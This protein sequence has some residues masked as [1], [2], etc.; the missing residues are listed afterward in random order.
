ML[1]TSQKERKPSA[2]VKCI[3]HLSNAVPIRILIIINLIINH[4]NQPLSTS[5]SAISA[6]E[7]ENELLLEEGFFSPN[8]TFVSSCLLEPALTQWA[9]LMLTAK[10]WIALLRNPFLADLSK[11]IIQ[12]DLIFVTNI[13]NYIRGEKIVMWRNFS[14]PCMTIVGKLKISPHVEKFQYN[15][16]GFIAIYAVLLLNLLFAL[17]C[18]EIFA[19][20]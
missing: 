19:T 8:F 11:Y 12:S 2:Q 10:W 3:P 15:W 1:S 4:H 7:K 20:I 13:T 9:L 6:S 14:F 16:W 17:F 5:S 18:R